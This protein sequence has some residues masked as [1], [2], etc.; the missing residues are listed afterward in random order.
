MGTNLKEKDHDDIF[1]LDLVFVAAVQ[2][3][4][5]LKDMRSQHC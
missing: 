1:F 3:V 5:G 4:R 2:P